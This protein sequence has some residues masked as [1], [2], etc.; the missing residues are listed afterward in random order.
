M[1]RIATRR[2]ALAR[3]QAFQ[4]G[5]ALAAGAGDSFELVPMAATGD[6]QPR[7]AVADF[8]TKGLFVDTLRRAVASGDCDV[9]VHSYKDLPTQPVDGLV[10]AAVPVREDPRDLLVTREGHTLESLPEHA[11][12]GTSSQRRSLQ[13][14]CV[15]PGLRVVGIRG[16]LDTRLRAVAGGELDAVVVARAGVRRLYADPSHGGVG[17]MAL[18]LTTL[19]LEPSECL[20][21]PGQGALAVECRTG[22][23]RALAA[24][25]L[26]DDPATRRA[27]EAERAFLV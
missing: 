9:A 16:N 27:V 21:A 4:V 11:T 10:V 25:R 1:L 15:R 24:C 26:L 14:R 3:A 17:R 12:V 5:R 8:E 7:R 19:A 6:V 13:L 22:D 2:S 23:E 20:P 18:P